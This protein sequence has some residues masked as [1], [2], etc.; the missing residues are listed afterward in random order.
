MSCGRLFS[1]RSCVRG[2]DVAVRG[3][4]AMACVRLSTYVLPSPSAS[5]RGVWG[6]RP[7]TGAFFHASKVVLFSPL[8]R[9]RPFQPYR[10]LEP[11]SA[12]TTESRGTLHV[13]QFVTR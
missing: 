5:V 1:C 2:A 11:R 13:S 6:L 3:E 9:L 10:L 7:G 4:Y 8:G 12:C